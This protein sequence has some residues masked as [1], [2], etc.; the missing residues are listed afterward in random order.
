MGKIVHVTDSCTNTGEI[1]RHCLKEAKVSLPQY[2]MLGIITQLF[3][4]PQHCAVCYTSHGFS[5]SSFVGFA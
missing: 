4:Y 2:V 3:C 1:D 5:Q